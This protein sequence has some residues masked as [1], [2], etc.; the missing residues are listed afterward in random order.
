MVAGR[1]D[2]RQVDE[3]LA[4]GGVPLLPLFPVRAVAHRIAGEDHRV[5][6][7]GLDVGGEGGEARGAVSRVAQERE[8]HRRIQ[9]GFGRGG[10]AAHR[11]PAVVA[12]HAVAPGTFARQPAQAHDVDAVPRHL[13]AHPRDG[14]GEAVLTESDLRAPPDGAGLGLPYERHLVGRVGPGDDVGVLRQVGRSDEE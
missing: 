10:E 1:K 7:G 11:A 12:A 3:G 14:P 5:H 13:V 6:A 2:E 9:P 4:A 8:P